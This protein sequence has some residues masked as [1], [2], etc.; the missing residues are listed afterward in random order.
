MQC[1][2]TFAASA[3]ENTKQ[4][5]NKWFFFSIPSRVEV[6][7]GGKQSPNKQFSFQYLLINYPNKDTSM[8][9]CILFN[10]SNRLYQVQ[11]SR[12]F[13]ASAAEN[14]R[15]SPNKRFCFRYPIIN[16]PNKTTSSGLCILF[17][18]SNRLYRVQ[19][20]RIFAA[21]A[22]ENARQSPNKRFCFRYPIINF[23]NK[24]TSSG[25]CILFNSSNRLY[26]VQCSRIFAASAAENAR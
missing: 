15:Q 3:A 16:F 21:S 14:A 12:I 1:R 22:A 10:S 6:G 20:S 9:L 5:P 7:T 26:R 25:L 11:C 23:P 2:G 13:A 18:S 24:T 17:N 19:C 8:G 4:S